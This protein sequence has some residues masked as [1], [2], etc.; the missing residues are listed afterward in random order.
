[1]IKIKSVL[2]I[3]G[4]EKQFKVEKKLISV[5]QKSIDFWQTHPF[6]MKIRLNF[7]KLN[8]TPWDKN[9]KRDSVSAYVHMRCDTLVPLYAPVHI[10]HTCKHFWMTSIPPPLL[11]RPTSLPSFPWMA[12][13]L[14]KKQIRTY[15]YRIHW[16]I[17]FEKNILGSRV[18]QKPKALSHVISY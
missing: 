9:I 8:K 2:A 3:F 11:A 5:Q 16:N 14:T 1:M 4:S 6:S 18:N 12:Y 7:F 15:E 17:A 10:V 13:F